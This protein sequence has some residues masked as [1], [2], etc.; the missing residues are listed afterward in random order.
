MATAAQINQLRTLPVDKADVLFLQLMI[1]HHQAGIAMA[2]MAEQLTREP[3]VDGL[4]AT[5]VT[6]QHGDITRI[7]HILEARGATP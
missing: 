6:G 7:S 3:V 1:K 2:Q 5:V 4:A